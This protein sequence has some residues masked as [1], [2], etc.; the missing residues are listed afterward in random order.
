MKYRL[1][2]K[3]LISKTLIAIGK[4]NDAAIREAVLQ[5]VVLHDKVVLMGIDADVR[6]IREAVI[7]D[8]A[9]DTMNVRAAGNTMNNMIGLNVIQPLTIIYLRISRFR[10]RQES[11]ITYDATSI[12]NDKACS[13]Q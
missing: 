5:D 11:K 9:E 13:S 7:H 12:F 4:I 10:R 3:L 2:I 6:I 8:A 1:A